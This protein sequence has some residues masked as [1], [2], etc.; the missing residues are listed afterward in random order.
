[1]LRNLRPNLQQLDDNIQ[2]WTEP[3]CGEVSQD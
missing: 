3:K 1:M 2:W